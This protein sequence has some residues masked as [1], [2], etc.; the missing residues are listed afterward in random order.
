[1]NV[2]FKVFVCLYPQ[3]EVLPPTKKCE[4]LEFHFCDFEHSE[5]DLVKCGIK[6][7]YELKVV[8]KF[9][10]PREVGVV[11]HEVAEC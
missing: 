4:I 9:H 8:D 1:M 10:I 11:D 6:M 7:Y 2:L 5:L 3:S